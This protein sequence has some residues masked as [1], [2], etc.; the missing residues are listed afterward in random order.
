MTI[1]VVTGAA[2]AAALVVS[3]IILMAFVCIIGAL[4]VA[5]LWVITLIDDLARM[6][7]TGVRVRRLRRRLS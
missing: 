2:A 6:A 3:W 5:V 7:V 1:Y 4:V